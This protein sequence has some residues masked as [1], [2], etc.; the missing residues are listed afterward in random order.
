MTKQ[1]KIEK[2]LAEPLKKGDKVYV[3]GLGSQNKKSWTGVAEVS[4]IKDGIPYIKEHNRER[5]ITE[6]WRKATYNIGADPFPKRR[7]MVKSINYA[8]ESILFSLFK[9]DKYDINDTEIKT[10][11]FNPFVIINGKKNY[12]QRPLVWK[13]EDK[14]L[15]I[16]SI[17]NSVDCGK[18][19]IR[20]RG[21]DELRELEKGGHELSWR[22]VVDG[23]QRL[24]ALKEFLD[25]KFTDKLGNYFEDL[26]SNAQNSV[27]NHQL[28]SYSELPEDTSD[29]EVLKQFLRLNFA[30]VP[31]SKEHINFV[32]SL[33]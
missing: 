33:L 26:S 27:T 14:Q 17:Y 13:L 28:F 8:L 29:E 24:N 5:E 22:D 31:Q 23:K 10:H 21:W 6:E 4:S 25:G 11:N 30:G 7:D 32:K 12:Y 16:E 1:E 20:L 15:L 9:E 2:Y 3:Q 19:L 18:I